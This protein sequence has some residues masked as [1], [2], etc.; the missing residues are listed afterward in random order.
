MEAKV[1]RKRSLSPSSKRAKRSVAN[2]VAP[3]HFDDCWVEIFQWLDFASHIRVGRT[4]RLFHRLLQ[5]IYPR[6]HTLFFSDR[7][8]RICREIPSGAD[9]ASQRPLQ[10]HYLVTSNDATP[11]LMQDGVSTIR[12]RNKCYGSP[13]ED[14]ALPLPTRLSLVSRLVGPFILHFSERDHDYGC[15]TLDTRVEEREWVEVMT[16]SIAKAQYYWNET[17]FTLDSAVRLRSYRIDSVPVSFHAL[18]TGNMPNDPRLS[19]GAVLGDSY[20]V[21]TGWRLCLKTDTW[22]EDGVPCEGVICAVDNKLVIKLN[23][24]LCVWNPI[25]RTSVPLEFGSKISHNCSVI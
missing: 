5:G 24:M 4:C 2:S 9:P 11:V 17:M 18:K 22:F 7:F 21:S 19:F 3:E 1:K 25:D 20:Y 8:N 12:V 6:G 13:W 23:R 16:S 14:I 10:F 15:W